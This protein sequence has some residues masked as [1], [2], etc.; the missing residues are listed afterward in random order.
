MKCTK[1]SS[2]L[3]KKTERG[4]EVDACPQ[5][6]GMWLDLQELDTLEDKGYDQDELKGTLIFSSSVSTDLCPHCS[7]ALAQFQY[8]LYDLVLEYCPQSHGYWLDAG[9]E[10]RVVD[11]MNRRERDMQRSQDAEAGWRET[12]KGFRSR[13]FFD[14]LKDLMR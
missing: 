12:L 6:H 8:R 9:E 7:S 13:S 14:K 5:G 2:L 3:E 1:C 4:L 10:D 11:L